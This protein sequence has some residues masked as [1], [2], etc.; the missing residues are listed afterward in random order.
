[1]YVVI[2]RKMFLA[3]LECKRIEYSQN[4]KRAGQSTLT[5]QAIL[6]CTN[7]LFVN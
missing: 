3:P 7:S 2:E 4:E 1:M 6:L 5:P